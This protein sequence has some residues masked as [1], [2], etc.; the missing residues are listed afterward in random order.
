MA[1]VMPRNTSR[2]RSRFGFSVMVEVIGY[3]KEIPSLGRGAFGM[4]IGREG[5]IHPVK[6]KANR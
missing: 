5:F 3:I 4:C 6:N 2:E 1:M